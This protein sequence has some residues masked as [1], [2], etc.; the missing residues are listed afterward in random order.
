MTIAQQISK[1]HTSGTAQN[2][3]GETGLGQQSKENYLDELS[4]LN[5]RPCWKAAS[6][7]Q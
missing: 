1:D 3:T 7:Q 6:K 5:K 2:S 4:F